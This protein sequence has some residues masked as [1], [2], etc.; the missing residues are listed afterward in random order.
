MAFI[1]P[2]PFPF[3]NQESTA[4]NINFTLAQAMELYWRAKTISISATVINGYGTFSIARDLYTTQ[5]ID[6]LVCGSPVD[7]HA[8]DF[9]I[10]GS[11]TGRPIYNK[12]TDK[13]APSMTFSGNIPG[14]ETEP[15]AAFIVAAPNIGYESSGYF[16]V[17]LESAPDD[18]ISIGA[19]FSNFEEPIE[20]FY[21]YGS[22]SIVEYR[23]FSAYA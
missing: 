13:Y 14:S 12:E 21:G 9:L 22:I 17:F 2:Q 16:N 23:D 5:T 8:E 10:N 18:G 19:V 7:Y 1:Y 15:G 20:Y 6:D 3:C 4:P 11:I